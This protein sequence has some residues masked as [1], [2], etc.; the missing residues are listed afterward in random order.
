MK[1]IIFTI[2]VIFTSILHSCHNYKPTDD[3][4]FDNS[5]SILKIDSI[6]STVVSENKSYYV[7]NI[8]FDYETYIINGTELT[9][10]NDMDTSCQFICIKTI[11]YNGGSSTR[12][13]YRLL[14]L[15]GKNYIRLCNGGRYYDDRFQKFKKGDRI[16]LIFNKVMLGKVSEIK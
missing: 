14:T 2:F 10:T 9:N 12:W 16:N 1:K 6:N 5:L 13:Y 15:D 3:Y 11:S 4:T 7:K 8:N